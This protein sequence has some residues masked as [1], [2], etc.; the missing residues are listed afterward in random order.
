MNADI[1]DYLKRE[2]LK[3][4]FNS[5]V[6]IKKENIFDCAF[7]K[8]TANFHNEGHHKVLDSLTK[9]EYRYDLERFDKKCK[10]EDICS[11]CGSSD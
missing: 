7:C 11:F 5:E 9:V 2:H 10:G 6:K 3:E 4:L 1:F 8:R